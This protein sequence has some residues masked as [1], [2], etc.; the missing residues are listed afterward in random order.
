M[1][2]KADKVSRTDTGE[3]NI[4]GAKPESTLTLDILR[5]AENTDTAA[6]FSLIR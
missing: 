2:R 5:T 6:I 1:G 3:W 4:R